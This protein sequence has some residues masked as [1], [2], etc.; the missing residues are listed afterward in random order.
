MRLRACALHA[1]VRSTMRGAAL[2]FALLFATPAIAAAQEPDP[3][4]A[5][6]MFDEYKR[7]VKTAEE[8]LSSSDC[9]SACLALASAPTRHEA[10]LSALLGQTV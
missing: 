3:A 8:A 5:P 1:S 6:P 4:H 9:K 10:D 7:A 2:T